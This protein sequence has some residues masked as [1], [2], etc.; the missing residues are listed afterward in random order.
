MSEEQQN[1]TGKWMVSLESSAK[2]EVGASRYVQWCLRCLPG[3][4][5]RI[6]NPQ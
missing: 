2:Q 3:L 5:T 6:P 4:S 1:K